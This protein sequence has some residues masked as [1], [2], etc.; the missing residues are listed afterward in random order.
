M[1]VLLL[2]LLLY[3]YRRPPGLK[4]VQ[5]VLDF[6]VYV[7]KTVGFWRVQEGGKGLKV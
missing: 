4:P 2:L 1:L 7:R 6:F 3:L 5:V